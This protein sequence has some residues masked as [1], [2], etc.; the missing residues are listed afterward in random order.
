MAIPPLNR[1]G[2]L[3]PAEHKTS[4]AS[5]RKRF[6]RSSAQRKEL[7]RG[8][9]EAAGNLNAAGVQRIWIN[10]S[11]VTIKKQPNPHYS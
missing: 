5:V 1:A 7:M 4:L 8:L 6:G 10:G 2:E 11:F 9:E 3:P